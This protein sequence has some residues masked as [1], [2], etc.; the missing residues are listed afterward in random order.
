MLHEHAAGGFLWGYGFN[1]DECAVNCA[2]GSRMVSAVTAKTKLYLCVD[3]A[4]LTPYLEVTTR[5]GKVTLG[6]ANKVLKD[7]AL[8]NEITGIAISTSERA[9]GFASILAVFGSFIQLT[10]Y[11]VAVQS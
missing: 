10:I 6:A 8:L 3:L 9:F 1:L 11:P 5:V 2:V 4:K 7:V